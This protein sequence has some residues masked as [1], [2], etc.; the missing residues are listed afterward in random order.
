[1]EGQ[2]HE[3]RVEEY[4]NSRGETGQHINYPDSQHAKHATNTASV[5]PGDKNYSMDQLIPVQDVG[6]KRLS[7]I[8]DSNELTSLE[9]GAIITDTPQP[10]IRQRSVSRDEFHA[11]VAN[12]DDKKN[13]LS[14]ARNASSTKTTN[15][16]SQTFSVQFS[17][18]PDCKVELDSNARSEAPEPKKYK[19]NRSR[20]LNRT[21]SQIERMKILRIPR[22][23][24]FRRLARQL[25][26]S[27]KHDVNGHVQNDDVDAGGS[28]KRPRT[29]F[30]LAIVTM[31]CCV[32]PLGFV[33]VVMAGEWY[34]NEPH[35]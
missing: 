14:D 18:Y 29:F 21:K 34:I 2:N 5:S 31:C 23:S 27:A 7:A 35:Y 12:R 9:D 24:S 20:P 13:K 11:V 32:S 3:P 30:D 8:S 1:M 26:G 17:T 33:A 6:R 16:E 25:S 15:G 10:V 22:D 28:N 4:A 19:I